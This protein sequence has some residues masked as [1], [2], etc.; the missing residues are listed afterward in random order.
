MTISSLAKTIA[1]V[2]RMVVESVEIEDVGNDLAI[3]LKVRTTKRDSC[4]C[5]VCGKNAA[6][7][8]KGT[9]GGAGEDLISGT[10]TRCTRVC[11]LRSEKGAKGGPFFAV[12]QGK[13]FNNK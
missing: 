7:M 10:V 11:H 6:D 8:T 13:T 2:K 4:R 3:V 5:G 12:K 1:G 9:A